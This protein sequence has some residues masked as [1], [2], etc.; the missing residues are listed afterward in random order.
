MKT[1]IVEETNTTPSIIL[2]NNDKSIMIKGK[3]IP[4][5]PELFWTL[6]IHQIKNIKGL[7]EIII[8]LEYI[9][10]KSISFIIKLIN[11]MDL[12]IVWLYDES[13]VDSYELGNILKTLTKN[14]FTVIELEEELTIK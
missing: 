9:N 8:N 2:D 5:E 11:I 6:V 4:F 13:D 7:K 10:T 1:I 14:N 12:N 3:T